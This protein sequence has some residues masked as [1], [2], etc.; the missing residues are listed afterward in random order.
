MAAAEPTFEEAVRALYRGDGAG[1]ASETAAWPPD[2][3]DCSRRLAAKAFPADSDL[4][5]SGG[6]TERPVRR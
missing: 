1:F 3:R 2:V 5:P 6:S 4:Y